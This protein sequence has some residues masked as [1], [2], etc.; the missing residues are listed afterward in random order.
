MGSLDVASWQF[1]PVICA[2]MCAT[3][4]VILRLLWHRASCCSSL[5]FPGGSVDEAIKTW[6]AAAFSFHFLFYEATH[7]SVTI[8]SSLILASHALCAPLHMLAHAHML[9]PTCSHAVNTYLKKLSQALFVWWC[10]LT[11]HCRMMLFTDLWAEQQWSQ[12]VGFGLCS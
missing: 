10:V 1:W 11:C 3:Q 9:Q 6:T 5:P 12:D 7:F 2:D 8:T 4:Y